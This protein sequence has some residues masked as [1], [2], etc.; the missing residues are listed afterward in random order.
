MHHFG[1]QGASAPNFVIGDR[2]IATITDPDEGTFQDPGIVTG[3]VWLGTHWEYFLL[4]DGYDYSDCGWAREEL[5]LTAHSQPILTEENWL[6][7]S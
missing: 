1:I 2:V 3:M 4:F 6:R 5:T 7:A